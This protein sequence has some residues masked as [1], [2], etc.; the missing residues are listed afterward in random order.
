[1]GIFR[2]PS[3][4]SDMEA[5]TL[6]EWTVK[7][8]DTVRRGDVVAV[9][10]TQKGAI[11]IEIFE[12]GEIAELTAEP[13]RKLPVGAAM[14]VV[15][16][17]GEAR[18]E[19]ALSRPAPPEAA[20]EPAIA[21]AAAAGLV[22]PPPR[23]GTR[24]SPAARVRAR[25]L[26]IDLATV[27]GTG[28][29]G[30]IV[31]GDLEPGAA[32]AHEAG[33]GSKRTG[34]NMDEMRKA[35]AA[36]MTRSKR[37]IPHFYISQTIDVDPAIRFLETLNEGRPP[38]GRILPGAL[39]VRAAALAAAQVGVVNGHFTDAD[40]FRPAATVNA[41]IAVA[42]RGGGLVAP[43]LIDAAS[44]TLDE[45]MAGMRDLVS[46]ARAGRLR[47]SEMTMGT[48]TISSLGETGAEAMTGVIFPPQVALVGLGAPHVRPWV[49]DGAIVPRRVVGLT[50]S[51]DH[52]VSD[53]RQI[54]RFVSLFDT[55]LQTPEEL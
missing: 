3:L 17:P 47:S 24:A 20:P 19:A 55:A 27:T 4:G 18:P 31:L 50:V 21:E 48:I 43:A 38:T 14:A 29:G 10:E 33:S 2:M 49:V 37:T 41:G 6:V 36:A 34:P 7:P 52:R 53:G 9:V 28:P 39:F 12:D 54:A 46:R 11:E 1:M 5:G 32:P 51:A 8:G 23:T 40:G 35:I 45:T 22:E 15:L 42:L 30:A 16:K 26:G 13:G 25:E 44:L